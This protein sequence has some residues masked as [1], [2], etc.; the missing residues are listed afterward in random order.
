MSKREIRVTW[1]DAHGNSFAIYEEHEIPHAAAV[2]T[3]RGLELKND[4]AGITLAC[5]DFS[6]ATYRGV[7]FIPRGMIIKVEE[8]VPRTIPKRRPRRKA[9]VETSTTS[10]P[11]ATPQQPD[12]P[13]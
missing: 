10:D 12:T 8:L 4:E 13:L 9:A 2:A 5:E 3:T 1:N 7:T 11:A 6:G